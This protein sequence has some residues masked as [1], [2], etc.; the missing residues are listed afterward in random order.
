MDA[1]IVY[2]GGRV[3]KWILATNQLAGTCG[4]CFP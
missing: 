1:A 4:L 2:I 3:T